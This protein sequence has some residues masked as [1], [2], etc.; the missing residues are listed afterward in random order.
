MSELGPES[1]KLL[2][3]ARGADEPGGGDR[4]RVRG[5]I[6]AAIAA[7]AGATGAGEGAASA[8]TAGGSVAAG[9]LAVKIALAILA[10]GA[11]ATGAFFA[12][13]GDEDP[14]KQPE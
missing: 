4:D 14:P 1:R 6:A 12:F 8:G 5:K 10:V 2:D 7:G 3:L 9:G 13:R 11:V